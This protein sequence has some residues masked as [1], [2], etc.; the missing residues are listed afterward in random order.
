MRIG[1][2][3][4]DGAEILHQTRIH[5]NEAIHEVTEIDESNLGILMDIAENLLENT[6]I[7]PKK[8]AQLINKKSDS[9]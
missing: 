7:L 1:S 6:Y 2:F 3:T 8:A 4:Q 9:K 5:G